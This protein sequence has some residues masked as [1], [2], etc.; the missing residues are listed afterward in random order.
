MSLQKICIE[1]AHEVD[2][3][4]DLCRRLLGKILRRLRN[5]WCFK[6]QISILVILMKMDRL[7]LFAPKASQGFAELVA[8]C[9]RIPLSNVEQV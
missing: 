1:I 4:G 8:T 7:E 5:V 6:T 9:L 2:R 3:A